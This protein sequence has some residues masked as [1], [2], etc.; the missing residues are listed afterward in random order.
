MDPCRPLPGL[1]G[2]VLVVSWR[3]KLQRMVAIAGL[4]SQLSRCYLSCKPAAEEEDYDAM[5]FIDEVHYIIN[6]RL[7]SNL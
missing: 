7:A 2:G 3:W 5:Y 6:V 1:A 4:Y